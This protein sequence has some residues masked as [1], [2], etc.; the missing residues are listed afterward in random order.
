MKQIKNKVT[1]LSLK[2]KTENE[3]RECFPKVN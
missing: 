2:M 3:N 1:D